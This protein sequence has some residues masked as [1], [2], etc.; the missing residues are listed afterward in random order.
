[1]SLRKEALKGLFWRS[2]FYGASTEGGMASM[3]LGL[4]TGF[5]KLGHTPVFASSGRMRLPDVVNYYFIPYSKLLMNLPEVLNLPYNRKVSKSLIKII[6]K[7]KPDFLYQHHADLNYSGTIL[8]RKL[9]LP[10][11]LQCESVQYWVK[12]NWGKLYLKHHLK[13]AEEIQ[14]A[15]ADAIFVVSD[16]VKKMMVELGVDEK[17]IYVNRSSVNPDVF[18]PEIDGSEIRKKL[19]I[20]SNFVIGFSGSFAQWHG[21]EVLAQAVKYISKLI[22]KAKILFIGDGLLRP[23]IESIIK[24]DNVEKSCI[25]TGLVP[26]NEMPDYLA[27]CDVLVTPCV[28]TGEGS[29]FFNSPIKLYE[30]LSMGKPVVATDIGEQGEVIQHLTNGMLCSEQS[31]EDLAES[32]NYIYKNPDF[33]ETIAANARKTVLD[34]YDWKLNAQKVIEI[35]HQI[36]NKKRGK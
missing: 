5:I 3:H 10:F 24:N 29:E 12:K 19:D 27:A 1:M 11:I 17:K 6:E 26:F 14:W 25:L 28:R 22:P 30:Y 9:G 34:K 21:V 32:I 7:E 18:S 35:Y 2:D 20:E 31:P 36:I 13:W 8:K 4:L 23:K 33:A 16:N 15:A